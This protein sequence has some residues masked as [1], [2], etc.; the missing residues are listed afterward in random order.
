MDIA[1]GTTQ[2][3]TTRDN[4]TDAQFALSVCC[5]APVPEYGSLRVVA[6]VGASV[7][8]QMKI[9]FTL[10]FNV[11]VDVVVSIVIVVS[12]NALMFV[13]V[14]DTNVLIAQVHHV[15]LDSVATLGCHSSE[16]VA[17]QR[18]QINDQRI[19]TRQNDPC[20]RTCRSHDHAHVRVPYRDHVVT[21]IN[22]TKERTKK[23]DKNINKH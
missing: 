4:T 1:R 15:F 13:C 10:A 17:Q 5:S 23:D 9:R 12:V 19:A 6:H 3:I 2:Q 11:H 20:I 16:R 14:Y 18:F 8:L 22:S 7:F 21:K